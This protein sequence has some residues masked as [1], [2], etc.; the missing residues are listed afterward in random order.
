MCGFGR[1]SLAEFVLIWRGIPQPA[2]QRLER[3][4]SGLG[5]PAAGVTWASRLAIFESPT[6]ANQP[7]SL[8]LTRCC[9]MQPVAVV[10]QAKQ[11]DRAAHLEGGQGYVVATQTAVPT[12]PGAARRL[13]FGKQP[14]RPRQC[15]RSPRTLSRLYFRGDASEADQIWG[16]SRAQGA[17]QD[18][19]RQG[20]AAAAVRFLITVLSSRRRLTE[21]RT[22]PAV[23]VCP[24]ADT[25]S[26][27]VTP[28][29]E[30]DAGMPATA[31][32]PHVR[33]AAVALFLLE[34]WHGMWRGC[35]EDYETKIVAL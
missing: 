4:I 33:S 30:E 2:D 23:L 25:A 31:G 16:N 8:A 9:A 7:T 17:R 14:R 3:P 1:W 35:I 18:A 24:T 15:T 34:L 19:D 11:Q 29:V 32:M 26:S 27:V 12:A 6:A 10:A 5:W 20:Q 22:V 21:A 28:S 13:D